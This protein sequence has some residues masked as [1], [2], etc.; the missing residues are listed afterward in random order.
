MSE[1]ADEPQAQVCTFFKKRRNNAAQLRG[2]KADSDEEKK[3]QQK[4]EEP[5]VKKQSRRRESD[6]EEDDE[7]LTSK[8]EKRA[9]K[10]DSEDEDEE[11]SD[12]DVAEN[13][14]EMKRKMRTKSSGLIQ[15][16]K[17]SSG[18]AKSSREDV[19]TKFNANRDPN[20][21]GPNDMGAT[22]V[23]N[24]DTEFDRDARAVMERAQKLND[25]LKANPKEDASNV[26]RG[27]NNYQQFI[28]P[29]ETAQGKAFNP[30]G[31]MRAP[32]NLRVSF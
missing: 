26:Y 13:L 27:M 2:S 11:N 4:H 3:Q 24:L 15:S 31:P 14:A 29:R 32:S 30:K 9:Q 21:V 6:S 12:T 1:A 18:S 20:R 10:S 16:S 23:Y 17:S 25:E 5:P 8:P 28:K 22:A 7:E 19:V